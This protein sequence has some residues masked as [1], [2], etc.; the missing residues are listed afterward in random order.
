VDKVRTE[1]LRVQFR[2]VT[3]VS[4]FVG[5]GIRFHYTTYVKIILLH[6]HRVH[7]I[8]LF[9]ESSRPRCVLQKTAKKDGVVV[10]F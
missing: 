9:L 7:T 4:E 5:T 3:A 10:N 2:F 1:W 6:F 8:G